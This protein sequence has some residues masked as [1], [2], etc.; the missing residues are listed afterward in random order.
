[1]TDIPERA[2]VV[3]IGGGVIGCS[4]AYHLTKLGWQDVV[5]LERKQ[6]TSGTTWHAAGLIA[7]LR[8][9][10]NMTKLAKYSQ[11]LYGNLEE[12]TG[13]ATGFK[14]CGSITVALT[15]E[16]REE[17]FR[18]AAMA[19]AFGVDVEEISPGEVKQRY[20]H[21]NIDGVTGGVY[22]DKDGQGDPANIALA[23]AKG[24]RQRGARV[25]ERTRVS[26][27][28]REG[29]RV[30]GVDWEQGA[31]TGHIACDMIVNCAGMWGHEVGRMAGVN[32]PLHACE[33]FYIVSEPIAG[34]T[35]MPVLRVPDEC[36]YYKEDAGKILLGAFEPVAKPWRL[37]I[38]DAF[39]FD[40]LPEDFDHFEPVLEAAVARM[41]MLAD[42]GIHTFFNGPESFTPDDAYHL[43]LAPE[44]DNVWVAAGFN[45]IGIQSAGGAGMALAQ[46]MEDG[47]K[48]FDLGDVDITRMQPFQG[49][50]RYLRE[51]STET[52]GLLYADHFPYRQKATARG[53][54]RTP[55][56][57][58]LLENGAVMGELAGWERANWFARPGQEPEY[59]YSWKRQNF[60]DNVAEEVRAVRTNLGMYDMSSFGKIRVEG[61]DATAF[62]NHVGGGQYDVPVGKIVYTQFLNP[63]GG[64]EAD[65]TV[66]RLSET[67]YLVVTPAA[68]RLADETWMRRHIGEFNVVITDVTAGEGVLAVM[69]PKAR[70]LLQ[71]VSPNDFSNASNPFG[72]AQ[73]IE[74]GLGLARVHRVTYVGELGW[75][76]YVSA[77]MA[78]HAFETLHAAGQEFG[79][80]LCGMHM[81]DCARIE[82][83]FRH[84][85]HDITPEDHVLEAGLGF[86]VKTDKPDFIGRDAVLRKKD[87]GLSAR[88]LQFRLKDPEP[89]LYHNEPILRDGKIVG[90]LSSGAYGHHLGGAMGL[91][92]VPC[93]GETAAQV[94]SSR[95]EI[96]VA[97]TRVAAE[98]SLKPMYDPASERVK[99]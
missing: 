19:R 27:I 24:A 74:L 77:D 59:S 92:Y 55:F 45:S 68:T 95:Y 46:W 39:E 75:E 97:G 63:T 96:D 94:L 82:K 21:L 88:L 70:D 42:A 41:P 4:V 48:P 99:V 71:A 86:A 43:G 32:V 76:V 26:G 10:A 90:Y 69:G 36:A 11:E 47:Q 73:D 8:A 25:I 34:L 98:A 16:R 33:H 65:V 23:L 81:M 1:M 28:R 52:L 89:L 60:F 7:Q 22:L 50:R 61:R 37:D 31:E 12:E 30:T 15:D 53:V 51:R 14:R 49:N 40:Q 79:L 87:E 20:E 6:L 13:V 80:K 84:F 3:I 83:G 5:L 54:R 44:M 57:R 29:R 78:A 72:T 58:Q 85:G 93:R 66:T 18:Q 91:G 9:T 64:I 62:M 67:A 38:P 35:Q 2:R 17:L 56:H